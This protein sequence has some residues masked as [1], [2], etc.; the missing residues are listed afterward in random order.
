MWF[1]DWLVKI[2]K[3]AFRLIQTYFNA[4]WLDMIMLALRNPYTWIPLYIFMLFWALQCGKSRRLKFIC[5]SLICFAITDFSSAQILKPFFERLRPCYD[6]DTT[7]VV[8]WI[9]ECGGKYS[10][11][12]S[13]ASNHFGLACFWYYSIYFMTR[14]KWRWLWI[15]AILISFAQVYVGIHFPLDVIGGALLGLFTGFGLARLF[16][17]WTRE[18]HANTSD[19][20]SLSLP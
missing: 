10:F 20:S 12:S 6:P 15:W 5:L 2:D 7:G 13:H 14:Q 4:P 8:R 16:E 18:Q 11:P 17:F 9:I 19:N 1:I 3:E